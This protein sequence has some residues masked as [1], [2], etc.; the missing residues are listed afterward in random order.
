MTKG[1]IYMANIN[2]GGTFHSTAEGNIV[3]HANEIQDNTN[4]PDTPKKQS[5]IN[6]DLLDRI[7]DLEDEVSGTGGST[8]LSE[9]VST[10]EGDASTTGSVA[11]A[12]V[13]AKSELIGNATTSGNTLGKLEDKIQA[14][15][16]AREAAIAALD[17]DE[18]GTSTDGKIT[19]QVTEADGKVTNVAVT[20]SDI[21]SAAALAQEVTDRGTAIT[22]LIGDA[23][24]DYNTLGK[25]EDKI[26]AEASARTAAI[27]ALDADKSGSSADGKV[28]V[29]VTEADG[30]VN[31]IHVTTN[32]IASAEALATEVINRDTAIIGLTSTVTERLNTQD[33]TINTR[34][35]QQEDMIELLNGSEVIVVDDHTTVVSPDTQ[36]IYR[37]PNID[38]ETSEATSY[39]DWM[40]TDTSVPTWRSMATYDF[41]GIDDEPTEESENFVKSGGVKAAINDVAFAN[42]EKVNETEIE[43]KPTNASDKLVKG[44]G[45]LINEA[46]ELYRF[47]KTG[48]I[49]VN[50][51]NKAS[52]NIV[53][54]SYIESNGQPSYNTDYY[55]SDYI[56]LTAVIGSLVV[57]TEASASAYYN[58]YDINKNIIA[59]NQGVFTSHVVNWQVN[60]AY[61]KF[62]VNKNNTNAF[63]TF[64]TDTTAS[65]SI[66]V[67]Y[68]YKS[69]P[70]GERL[71]ESSVK[72]KHLNGYNKKGV[73]NSIERFGYF[74]Y[75]ANKVAYANVS[76]KLFEPIPI[77]TTL[78]NNGVTI[79]LCE[80][81][82]FT[83]GPNRYDIVNGETYTT[84]FVVNYMRVSAT[85]GDLNILVKGTGISTNDLESSSVTRDKIANESVTE[86]KLDVDFLV[87]HVSDN[88]FNKLDPEILTNAYI[89]SIGSTFAS[90]DY[91]VSGYIPVTPGKTYYAGNN[92]TY[93]IHY[94]YIRTHEFYDINKNVIQ[95]EDDGGTGVESVTAPANAV[96]LRVS[97][98]NNFD[99]YQINEDSLKPY[100]DGSEPGFYLDGEMI[101]NNSIGR[102]KLKSDAYTFDFI[103][104]QTPDNLFNANDPDILENSY[105]NKL[106][107]TAVNSNYNVS[108]YIPISSEHSYYF[109][110]NGTNT[111][112]H[113]VLVR[114]HEFYDSDKNPIS[115]VDDGSNVIN[116]INSANIPSAAAYL[117]VSYQNRF[118]K[119]QVNEDSLKSYSEWYQSDSVIKGS[120]IAKE[121][122]DSDKL[123]PS[124]FSNIAP[125]Q[126]LGRFNDSDVLAQ[127]DVLTL[128]RCYIQKN[129]FL[130][131]DIN[132]QLTNIAFGVGYSTNSSNYY[133]D[134]AALWVEIDA[135]NIKQYRAYNGEPLLRTTVEHGMTFTEKTVIT[136]DLGVTSGK[137]TVYDDL[138]NSFE[139]SLEPAGVGRPFIENLGTNSID[140]S[141]SMFPRDLTKDVWVFG[142]SYISFTTNTRWPYYL[143]QNN[144]IDWF[145]N[146]QPGLSP[147][148]AVETLE[149][150]LTLGHKP[151]YL[152]WM[153]GMNGSTS[154][155]I[156]D[157][158]YVINSYQKL[159]IDAVISICNTNN[160]TPILTVIPTVPERQKTGFGI[161]IKSLGVRYIDFAKAVG[162]N[163]NGEWNL[164]LL[165]SDEVHPTALGAK[166]LASQVLIDCPEL[167]IID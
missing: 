127:N 20:T 67:P 160:I 122:I 157:E 19:V 34:M 41:P 85:A 152:I 8:L 164:G 37:E 22:N 71:A 35:D 105:I 123:N 104:T 46:E 18:T 69:V 13:D 16:S 79:M 167:T 30:K 142:D 9:R 53:D 107:S 42:N 17:A 59:T 49:Y 114:T 5:E 31:A 156:V 25:L 7:S 83:Q 130:S 119:Y 98:G 74:I 70:V 32:D 87:N 33:N 163:S 28:T 106:G 110:D 155:S 60:A 90:L 61:V 149:N 36:T 117:R 47:W 118:T 73:E 161:Y 143:A 3:A 151:K 52:N 21:A 14:E 82:T 63:V 62:S 45:V 26:Q 11:K 132:G 116:V 102:E 75:E 158:Q 91:N 2:I 165:S 159:Y 92:G 139:T 78:V 140:C 57:Y 108:G 72:L 115:F 88:L 6:E 121:S 24:T 4:Y 68:K 64:G 147:Q 154:E 153:L 138:G 162:T 137:V 44:G 39:T 1:N 80:D 103:E 77:G 96:Y 101:E 54:N 66:Y 131:C 51:L 27:N 145:C 55:I 97:Y 141:I 86:A 112:L 134:Y 76:Q 148:V 129:N 56:P 84:T 65:T 99:K 120:K 89:N 144:Q 43:Y 40:C 95:F 125:R 133:R 100:N 111:G 166:V 81:S 29:Q 94:V 146:S 109:G 128:P 136:L 15:V 135:T 50:L 48:A 150:L 124:I 58:I 23:A 93:S 113:D 38:A 126:N 12:I 10:L